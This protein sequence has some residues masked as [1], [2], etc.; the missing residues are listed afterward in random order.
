MLTKCVII[1]IYD[2]ITEEHTMSMDLNKLASIME[3]NV[4]DNK[5]SIYGTKNGFNTLMMYFKGDNTFALRIYA[6]TQDKSKRTALYDF[7]AS[8]ASFT[9]VRMWEGRVTANVTLSDNDTE[10]SAAAQLTEFFELLGSLGFAPCCS[11]CGGN[12]PARLYDFMKDGINLCEDCEGIVDADVEKSN[13]L[14]DAQ[15]PRLK[16]AL[17]GLLIGAVFTYIFTRY[18]NGKSPAVLSG[19]MDSFLGIMI[20]VLA[21]KLSAA[22]TGVK[23]AVVSAV[24]CFAAYFAGNVAWHANYFADFNRK[25][26]GQQQYVIDYCE[27]VDAGENPYQQALDSGDEDL[28]GKYRYL[29]HLSQEDRD[30]LLRRVERMNDHQTTLSCVKDFKSLMFSDYGDKMRKDFYLLFLGSFVGI[31]PGCLLFWRLA[32]KGDKAR[33]ALIP[34]PTVTTNPYDVIIGNNTN[35]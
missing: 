4:S 19:A 20:T 29:H 27:A 15:K 2:Y 9:F 16:K 33:Y 22:K 17:P 3:L 25:N 11:T 14:H 8:H 34:L 23:T 28:I 18:T 30:D 1:D 31:G 10:E 24:L 26:I 7:A 12:K 35:T 13:A 5:I 32:L 21:V 6:N